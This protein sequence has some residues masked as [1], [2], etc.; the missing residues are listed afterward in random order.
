ML[1]RK[2]EREIDPG[3]REMQLEVVRKI[4]IERKVRLLIRRIRDQ[5]HESDRI[6][7]RNDPFDRKTGGGLTDTVIR[8]GFK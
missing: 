4:R 8:D 6:Y 3:D 1:D 2:D 7:G 5:K